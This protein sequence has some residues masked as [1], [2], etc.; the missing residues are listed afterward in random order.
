MKDAIGI[1]ELNSI[2]KGYEVADKVLKASIVELEFCKTTCPGKFLII[3][4]GDVAAVEKS[5]E[6]SE[7]ISGKNQIASFIISN[8][9]EDIIKNI[10]KRVIN[11][12]N[13]NSIGIV[14]HSSMAK[15]IMV[16]DKALKFANVQLVRLVPGNLIG[17]KSYFI[18]SGE[19]SSVRESVDY[20]LKELGKEKLINFSIISAPTAELIENL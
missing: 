18:I 16:L 10:N 17:G 12:E 7:E 8:P 9:H 11:K 14:E 20:S 5:I 15:S 1:I 19:L 6:T 4:S 3:V 13:I 2:A